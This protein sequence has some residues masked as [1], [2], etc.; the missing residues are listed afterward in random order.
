MTSNH[1]FSSEQIEQARQQAEEKLQR[2]Q[3]ERQKLNT[4]KTKLEGKLSPFLD[5]LLLVEPPLSQTPEG[6]QAQ[7]PNL[8]PENL[9]RLLLLYPEEVRHNPA[10]PLLL[11][12]NP[13]L[14]VWPAPYSSLQAWLK[15]LSPEERRQFWLPLVGSVLRFSPL[16]E[17]M[18]RYWRELEHFFSRKDCP[19]PVRAPFIEMFEELPSLL[20]L[21]WP[22]ETATRRAEPERHLTKD[23][24]CALGALVSNNGGKYIESYLSSV[25]EDIVEKELT[26]PGE[27]IETPPKRC[28]EARKKLAIEVRDCVV[29][30]WWRIAR[31]QRG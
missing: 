28:Y 19:Y 23:L 9:P 25:V 11:L 5:S 31:L 8:R 17:A 4:L 29:S 2:L 10:L 6:L 20:R 30:S 21:L 22:S 24:L 27:P 13:N 1:F 18:L 26:L 16:F 3:Q 12:E 15:E 14:D 7:D